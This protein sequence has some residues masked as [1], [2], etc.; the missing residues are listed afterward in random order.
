LALIAFDNPSGVLLLSGPA[1]F[2]QA[3]GADLCELILI[4]WEM[5]KMIIKDIPRFLPGQQ[6]PVVRQPD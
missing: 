2:R 4:H 6:L 5:I 3:C 1:G